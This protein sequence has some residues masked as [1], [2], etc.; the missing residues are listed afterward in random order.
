MGLDRRFGPKFLHPGPGYGGSCFP[1]DTKALTDIARQA[2]RPFKIVDTVVQVNEEIKLRMV[3]RIC[4]ACGG[5]VAGL[6]IGIAGLSFKPETDDMREA[7][8]VVILQA[9]IDEGAVV[10]AF[11]PAAMDN[12]RAALPDQVV[13]CDDAYDTAT[14]ADCFVIMTEWN[15]FRSLDLTRLREVV[16]RPVVVDLRNVYEP[17]KMRDAGFE[18]FC[19]GR[20]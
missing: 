8:S 18:Y 2:G 9:L 14:D 12:A 13:Y 1:K 11:D 19:V 6:T 3:E 4:E 5:S 20:P 16:R 7:P 17:E 15:Q 10:K